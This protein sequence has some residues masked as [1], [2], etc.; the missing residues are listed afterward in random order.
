MHAA[1]TIDMRSSGL[2]DWL[3]P[4]ALTDQDLRTQLGSVH[5]VHTAYWK[6][7]GSLTMR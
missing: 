6:V 1:Y 4:E 2:N 3:E 7:P 5:L